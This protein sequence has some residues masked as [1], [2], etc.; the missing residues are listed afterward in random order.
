M[1]MVM[2]NI[3]FSL[4]LHATF[5]WLSKKLDHRSYKY[6]DRTEYEYTETI[7]INLMSS[8][9][10]STI[11]YKGFLVLIINPNIF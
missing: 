9:L 8:A 3:I 2:S 11:D 1:G 7:N 4:F 5:V 6:I 10:C